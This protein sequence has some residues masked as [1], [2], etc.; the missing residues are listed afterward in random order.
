[1][2]EKYDETEQANPF[3]SLPLEVIDYIRSKLQNDKLSHNSFAFTCQTFY[4][5]AKA[6]RLRVRLAGCLVVGDQF[7]SEKMLK[8]YPDLLLKPGLIMDKL[9]RIF[10]TSVWKYILWSLDV[11]FM[12]PMMVDCLP[13][14]E[15]GKKIA[16]S[17]LAQLQHWEQ[18][19]IT[20]SLN[21]ERH[22]EQYY[23]FSILTTLGTF[24]G[25]FNTWEWGEKIV[26][27]KKDVRRAQLCA[28]AHIVQHYYAPEAFN[29]ETL[30]R[31][32]TLDKPPSSQ[33]QPWWSAKSIEEI[34]ATS[35]F[36]LGKGKGNQKGEEIRHMRGTNF[37]A[38]EDL[39][40]LTLLQQTR[41]TKDLPDLKQKLIDFIHRVDLQHQATTV[42]GPG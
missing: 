30:T 15:E 5:L 4:R 24:I 39:A 9:G 7:E 18:H 26:F 8:V 20:Y 29:A 23:D 1:M 16:E 32:L 34:L 40:E 42:M 37:T 41:L 21:G 33:A 13:L 28:P 10:E 12:G 6:E 19:G 22:C 38:Q 11:K 25:Q 31:V 27:W 2:N 3:N 35:Q 17:L 36:A 14:T